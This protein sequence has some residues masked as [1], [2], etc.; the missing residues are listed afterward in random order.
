M[1]N[2]E[3]LDSHYNTLIKEISQILW[4][5]IYNMLIVLVQNTKPST[6]HNIKNFLVKVEDMISEKGKCITIVNNEEN[7]CIVSS[8]LNLLSSISS[9]TQNIV[10]TLDVKLDENSV[11]LAGSI[12]MNTSFIG[13]ASE[14]DQ[15]TLEEKE[16]EQIDENEFEVEE[17]GLFPQDDEEENKELDYNENPYFEFKKRKSGKENPDQDLDNIKKQVSLITT[18]NTKAISKYVMK[19]VETIKNH[20]MSKKIKQNRINYFATMM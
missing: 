10:P 18:E 17:E 19:M 15:S 6:S 16:P 4:D 2:A 14:I 13:S 20:H 8:V 9:I 12:I 7:N 1:R 5:R 3:S 11:K